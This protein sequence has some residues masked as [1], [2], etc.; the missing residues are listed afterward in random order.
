MFCSRDRRGEEAGGA[1]KF[2]VRETKRA[3]G[4]PGE[5]GRQAGWRWDA[6]LARAFAAVPPL[7]SH[8]LPVSLAA[9]LDYS[10]VRRKRG[11][12]GAQ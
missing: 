10:P 12:G 5:G 7:A 1:G 6:G 3:P 2:G 8:P 11:E 4:Y 9:S